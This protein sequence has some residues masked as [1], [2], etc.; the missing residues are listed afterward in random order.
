MALALRDLLPIGNSEE[1]VGPH[2]SIRTLRRNMHLA[3][4]LA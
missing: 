4:A 1:I 3:V 2:C